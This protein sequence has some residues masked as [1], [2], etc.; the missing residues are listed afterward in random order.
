MFFKDVLTEM[1]ESMMS[2]INKK[3][4]L[5]PNCKKGILKKNSPIEHYIE[6]AVA[7]FIGGCCAGV[8]ASVPAPDYYFKCPVC[9]SIFLLVDGKF[10]PLIKNKS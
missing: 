3:A 8:G 2:A 10:I 7:K 6:V 1:Q 4:K 9:K 5:C